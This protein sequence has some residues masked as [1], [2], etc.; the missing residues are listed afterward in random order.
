LAFLLSCPN[1]GPREATEFVYGG[2]V[3]SR[4]PEGAEVGRRDLS[5]Y[6]YFRG[7][8][9]GEQTEWWFHSAGC[10]R[11]L[12]AKRDTVSGEVSGTERPAD[13]ERL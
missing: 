1:C 5:S 2:E 13:R 10:G 4:P 11:W 3:S 12:L 8:A 7:N 6:L 9:A